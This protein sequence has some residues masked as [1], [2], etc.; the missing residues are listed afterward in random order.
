MQGDSWI[1]VP[2]GTC[3]KIAGASMEPKA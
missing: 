1:Y 3:S 2:Q